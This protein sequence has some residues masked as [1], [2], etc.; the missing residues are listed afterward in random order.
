MPPP[1]RIQNRSR[2]TVLGTRVSVAASWM[3][4]L[5]GY[6]G[7]SRPRPG[8]GILLSPCNSIH[9]WGVRFPLDV[10]FLSA[11][12]EVLAVREGLEP[13][14][15]PVRVPGSRY[16]LEVP[17]GTIRSSETAV[18]DAFVWTG[19]DVRRPLEAL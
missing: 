1:L 17:T 11:S 7:R 4:R 3:S 15:R 14:S 10:V 16:V 8:E 18:G 12:G 9:M 19:V 13:F 2:G 5:R 6:L